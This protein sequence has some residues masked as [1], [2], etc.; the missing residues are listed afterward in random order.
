[1]CVQEPCVYLLSPPSV[2]IG[3]TNYWKI[4]VDVIWGKIKRGRKNKNVKKKEERGK[5]K[6]ER[7][8]KKEER[9][10]KGSKEKEKEKMGSKKV[11]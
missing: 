6:E 8:K 10:E 4:S 11:K 7:G 5:K 3:N 1:M 2:V 9:E